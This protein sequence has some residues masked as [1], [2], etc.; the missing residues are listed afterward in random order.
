MS[1]Y[2]T[3]NLQQKINYQL[4]EFVSKISIAMIPTVVI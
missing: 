4:N 3:M 2:M 1:S